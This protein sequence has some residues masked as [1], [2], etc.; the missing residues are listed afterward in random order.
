MLDGRPM[1]EKWDRHFLKRCIL[2]AEASKDPSTRVGA[3]IARPDTPP[4]QVSDGFNGFPRGVADTPERL[5]DRDTKL[6]LIVH[7]ER[8][9]MLNAARL[10]VSV[11]GCTLYF[12][13]V[14]TRTGTWWGGCCCTACAIE[15]IQAGIRRVVT[16]PMDA[17]PERWLSDVQL[18]RSVLEEAGV[19]VEEISWPT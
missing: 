17:I 6:R 5:A 7:A 16:G 3:L 18:S 19:K 4:I 2:V 1:S 14:D 10:G 8:N 15:A 12:A 9:A 11:A 13:A